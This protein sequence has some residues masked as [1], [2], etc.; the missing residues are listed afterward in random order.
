MNRPSN[1]KSILI[2]ILPAILLAG[3]AHA[4]LY[5]WANTNYGLGVFPELDLAPGVVTVSPDPLGQY[6][7]VYK[8][9]LPDTNS[10]AGKERCESSGTETPTGEF[11]PSY[12]T[13]YYIGW[14]AMWSPMPVNPGWVCLFQMHGYGVTGQGAPMTLRCVNNDG[15]LWAQA[16]ANG[17]NVDFLHMPFLT[18]VWQNFVVHT[19]LSTNWSQGYIEVYYNGVL[20]TNIGGT[21]RWYGPT[22]DN[23]D[24]VWSDSYNKFKWGCYRSGA[25]DGMGYAIAYMSNA[26]VGSTYADV[27]PSGGGAFTITSSPPAVVLAPGEGT[28]GTV[29]IGFQSGF[30]SNVVLSASGLPGDALIHF[31]PDTLTNSG[32]STMTISTTT[33]TLPGSYAVSIVG[34]GG[35][36]T[37]SAP[38]TLVVSGFTLSAGPSSVAVNA[39]SS[40][41]FTVTVTTNASFSGSVALGVSGLP[42]DANANL[43]PNSFLQSGTSTLT[44]N[45]TSNAPSGNYPLTVSATN[46]NLV[47]NATVTLLVNGVAANPGSLLWTAGGVDANWSTIL[48]WTNGSAGG[49]GPPGPS[50][51]L[52]FTNLGAATAS[53][54]SPTGSGVVVPANIKSTVNANFSVINLTNYANAVNTSPNYVNLGIANGGTLTV[55]NNLQVGGYGTYDFGG[56][57]VVNLSI[58]GAGATLLV[59]NGEIAVC[60]GSASSGAHDATLDLSG[61]D[62]LVMEASQIKMGVE[63]NTRSGGILYLAKTNNLLLLSAGYGNSDNSG[64]PYSG[65]PALTV[66]HNKTAVGNGAQLYLGISNNFALDYATIGRG[67]ANDLMIFNPAFTNQNPSVTI[68]GTNGAGTPVGVYVVGDDSPGAGGSA[69]ATNDFTGGTVN[70]LINYLCVGRAR[71]GAND[72]GSSAGVLTFNNGSITANALVLGFLYPSGSNSVANGTAN[73]NGS[74]TLTVLTNITLAS[75]PNT[76]GT[77]TVQGTLNINGGTVAATNIMGAGGT[78][79]LNLYSGTLNLQPAWAAGPGV[80]SNLTTLTIGGNGNVNAALLTGAAQIATPNPVTIASNGVVAGDTFITAPSLVVNGALSP[81]NQGAGAITNSGSITFGPGGQYEVTVEDG[82][83]GPGLGWSFLQSHGAITVQSTPANPFTIN[84]GTAG[85]PADNFQSNGNYDWVIAT[86]GSIANFATNAFVINSSQF[87]NNLGAG[88]FYLHTAGN[89]LVLSF[90]NNLPPP[91][92][93]AINF[94]ANGAN[95]VFSGTNGV[96]GRNY[97]VLAA[98]NLELPLTNWTVIMTNSFDVNGD[99]YFTTPANSGATPWFYLLQLQ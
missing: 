36:T 38:L 29:S 18:N 72:T 31:V 59:T 76:G 58:S 99:F 22:W 87:D 33:G 85:S 8:Y 61:L 94:T 32:E 96:P 47:L 48:N 19:F 11:L 53:A 21:T 16:N 27:D 35:G 26:K 12:N 62:N 97:Y 50:N 39:G 71:E 13:D 95:D 1:I 24:G 81:G 88:S 7:L 45:T 34:T 5:W 93:V 66:G 14:R 67:D 40:T 51:S 79:A 92:P 86:G 56:N 15:Y 30:S 73:V 2:F 69:T 63:N 41:N 3:T 89:S 75:R 91:V 78:S 25:M 55:G 74:G 68:N 6:G 57:N 49:N 4:T 83:A 17:T 44:V 77:G 82:T 54:I 10:G 20:Q 64:S 28:N 84:V 23:V 52:V 70:A 46:G 90:T 60:E 9:Y 42:V 43:V 80:I 37:Q 98:T 65:S